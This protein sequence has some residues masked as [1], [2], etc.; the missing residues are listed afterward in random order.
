[1]GLNFAFSFGRSQPEAIACDRP[2]HDIPE[3]GNV[4][5]RVMER[6]ART[7]KLCEC[8]ISCCILGIG[9]ARNTQKDIGVQET[10]G[11]SHLVV[12]LVKPFPRNHVWQR[13][14]FIR[15]PGH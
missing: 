8:P 6:R 14:D 7:L 3:L 2:G 9:A 12:V 10:R 1:M 5:V 11:R 15:V 4:L 13:G